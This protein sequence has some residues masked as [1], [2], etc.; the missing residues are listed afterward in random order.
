VVAVADAWCAHVGADCLFEGLRAQVQ[1]AKDALAAIGPTS[2]G[3]AVSTVAGSYMSAGAVLRRSA[4][5]T[6]PEAAKHPVRNP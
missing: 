5:M 3:C 4:L 6:D 2:P 1:L